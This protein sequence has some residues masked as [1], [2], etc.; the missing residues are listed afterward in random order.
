MQLSVLI[1]LRLKRGGIHYRCL[2][3]ARYLKA[4]M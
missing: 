4:E 1:G 3:A 2:S